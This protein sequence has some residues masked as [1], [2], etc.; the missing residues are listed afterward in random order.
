MRGSQ[1]LGSSDFQSQLLPLHLIGGLCAVYGG[2]P[3]YEG[4]RR[5]PYAAVATIAL[6]LTVAHLIVFYV[7]HV[8]IHP[9]GV[10]VLEF[11][12]AMPFCP[13]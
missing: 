12:L 3:D 6:L 2:R 10:F 11:V 1:I 5:L 7:P 8:G 13:F 9:C 4:Q